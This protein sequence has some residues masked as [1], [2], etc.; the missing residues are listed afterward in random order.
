MEMIM[1][2]KFIALK[3][4]GNV[5]FYKRTQ[6]NHIDGRIR[7]GAENITAKFNEFL[8][9]YKPEESFENWKENSVFNNK[10]ADYNDLILEEAKGYFTKIIN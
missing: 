10:K 2:N 4:K 7:K 5:E 3:I 1:K 9:T 6:K 8:K